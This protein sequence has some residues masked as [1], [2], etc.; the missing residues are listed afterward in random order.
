MLQIGHIR[1][2]C[3]FPFHFSPPR[4]LKCVCSSRVIFPKTVKKIC[5]FDN[6]NSSVLCL[7]SVEEK[8]ILIKLALMILFITFR[9]MNMSM[10]V[11]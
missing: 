3:N 1:S 7:L 8:K 9:C 4:V 5:C 2:Y 6:E 10:E 11:K